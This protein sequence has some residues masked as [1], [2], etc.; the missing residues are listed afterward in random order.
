ML[1][2]REDGTKAPGATSSTRCQTTRPSRAEID[3]WYVGGRRSGL[4][5]LV[6]RIE[7]G[8]PEE[9]P[10]GGRHWFYRCAEIA[11]NAKL[12]SRPKRPDEMNH[13]HDKT[14]TL[15]ETRGGSGV[16]MA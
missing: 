10:S 11:G 8:Y 12:P 3:A 2:P 9:T 13:E 15:I 6:E 16:W 5:G 14:K 4:G 7:A 1:P